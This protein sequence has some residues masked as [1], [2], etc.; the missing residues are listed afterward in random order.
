MRSLYYTSNKQLYE[1]K[2]CNSVNKHTRIKTILEDI[3][4]NCIIKVKC[5]IKEKQVLI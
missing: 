1:N 2:I 4:L 3:K 5:I